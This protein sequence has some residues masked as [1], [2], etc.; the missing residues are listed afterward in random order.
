MKRRREREKRDIEK[1]WNKR[2]EEAGKTI[3]RP[4]VEAIRSRYS[5]IE[6]Q[7]SPIWGGIMNNSRIVL[8]LFCLTY[9][10]IAGNFSQGNTDY[11][12]AIK[13]RK[14]SDVSRI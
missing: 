9:R 6:L 11:S 7:E 10:L 12:N 2:K 13:I 5:I 8:L 3:S 1:R 14:V 4:S